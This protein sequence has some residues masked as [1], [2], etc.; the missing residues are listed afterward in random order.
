MLLVL[1]LLSSQLILVKVSTQ[2]LMRTRRMTMIGEKVQL[3]EDGS[4]RLMT[5]K[6][7]EGVAMS[8]SNILRSNIGIILPL[9][10]RESIIHTPILEHLAIASS[11]SS[12]MLDSSL[13]LDNGTIR[14]VLHLCIHSSDLEMD[15]T[16]TKL[17]NARSIH[18]SHDHSFIYPKENVYTL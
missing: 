17:Q 8:L 6:E 14:L 2:L 16:L 12:T 10:Q 15:L 11:P 3:E 7:Q 18:R 1:L 9:T 4:R 13:L 5:R